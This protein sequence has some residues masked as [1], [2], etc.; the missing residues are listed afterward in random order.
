MDNNSLQ[1]TTSQPLEEDGS[2]Q[3]LV[4]LLLGI[5]ALGC[6]LL[7]VLAF[8]FFRPDEQTLVDQYFPSATPTQTATRRP[9]ATATPSPTLTP[10]KTLTLTPTITSTPHVLITPARGETVFNETFDTNERKWYGYYTDS[11]VDIQNGKL[12]L[13]SKHRGYSA[14]AFC[15]TCPALDDAFYYQA[16]VSTLTNTGEFYGLA[17]CSPGYGLD[18]YLF[19][20]NPRRRQYELNKHTATG[21]QTLIT[22][23]YAP[24]LNGFPV[25]N[26]LGIGFDH[27]QMEFYLNDVHVISYQDENPLDCRRAGFYV[28]DAGFDMIADNVF[29]Y[30]VE[31]MLTPTP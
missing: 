27:G 10:T 9:T 1:D 23:Q 28:N 26:I 29:A 8:L 16:E 11:P 12:T 31:P 5:A 7:F 13:G 2:R 18:F 4:W 3:R 14:I 6:G 17:F 25:T 24:S 22:S 30:S 15:T 20:V 21:W 19:Q